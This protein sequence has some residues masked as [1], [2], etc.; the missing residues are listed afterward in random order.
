M[1]NWNGWKITDEQ[2]KQIQN[3]NAEARNTFYFDNL[4]RIRKMAYCYAQK[5]PRCKGLEED[6]IQGVYVD[7]TVFMQECGTP[8]TDGKTLSYFVYSSFRFAPY[9]GLAY[10]F[11]NNPK[12]LSG[13]G[14]NMYGAPSDMLSFDKPFGAMSGAKRR[15]DDNNARTLGEVVPAPEVLDKIDLTEELKTL[16]SDLLS[17]REN[18]Y[19]VHFIEGYGNAEIS[20]R[21]GY[22]TEAN[23]ADR[24]KQKLRNNSVLILSRLSAL[25]VNVDSYKGKT[26]YNPKTERNYKLSPEQR[27][28]GAESMRKQR[29]RKKV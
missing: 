7:L 19:F 3:G 11:E 13:G 21:M 20:R 26:P 12:L 4:E 29:A 23:N 25:G 28:R 1:T 6:L 17:P 24:V 2:C 15:Q 9:G 16:V 5:T 18:E 22:N 8:V 27:A 10:L 14:L